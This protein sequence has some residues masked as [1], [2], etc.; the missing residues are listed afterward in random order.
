MLR[1]TSFTHIINQYVYYVN[2]YIYIMVKLLS[3]RIST[4][5]NCAIC[6][7]YHNYHKSLLV[8]RFA[9][10][11]G[12][13]VPYWFA[14]KIRKIIPPKKQHRLLKSLSRWCCLYRVINNELALYL[15][16]KLC[17]NMLEYRKFCQN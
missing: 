5:I 15:M 3:G 14:P 13:C 2:Q 7:I 8:P 4:L 12:I 11:Y 9:R 6:K 10:I 16:T 1:T 17:Y